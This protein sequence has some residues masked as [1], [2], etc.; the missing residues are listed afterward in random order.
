MLLD[1]FDASINRIA[2]W[3]IGA[4]NVQKALLFA[5]V[6]PI[7]QLREYEAKG[8]Y[9]RRLA[10]TEEAKNLPFASVWD[11]YCLTQSVPVG[12]EWIESVA[13]YEDKV[14]SKRN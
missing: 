9:T 12:N 10:L 5:L 1:Y 7:A 14:L 3:V 11:Y 2:A 13:Q 8:D 6:Q 4:R